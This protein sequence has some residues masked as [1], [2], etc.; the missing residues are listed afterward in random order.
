VI[1]T[2]ATLIGS[3]VVVRFACLVAA[4]TIFFYT[5]F[6]RSIAQA[7]FFDPYALAMG[8]FMIEEIL[9]GIIRLGTSLSSACRQSPR[10]SKACSA[11]RNWCCKR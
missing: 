8:L 5:A 4:A 11:S 2:N 3:L 1:A 9:N 10:A 6:K 7:T